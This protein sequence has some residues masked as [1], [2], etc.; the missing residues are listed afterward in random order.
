MKNK[1]GKT[2]KTLLHEYTIVEVFYV[3]GFP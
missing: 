2:G 1:A 3:G